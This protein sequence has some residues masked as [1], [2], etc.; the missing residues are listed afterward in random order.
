MLGKSDLVQQVAT[1]TGLPRSQATRAVDALL[2]AVQDAVA[3]GDQVRISGFGS[4]RVTETKARKGRNPRTGAELEI[5]AGR[6]VSFTPGT[7]LVE[8]VRGSAAGGTPDGES[9]TAESDADSAA[10]SGGG[11]AAARATRGSG[12]TR[13]AARSGAAGSGGRRRTSS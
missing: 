6:R 2:A 9:S 8:S 12:Q 5:K 11:R 3:Q 1:R 13:G 7:K 4:F 10:G